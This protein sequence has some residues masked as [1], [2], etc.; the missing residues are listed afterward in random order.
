MLTNKEIS[1]E[2]IVDCRRRIVKDIFG[3]INNAN[4]NNS[5]AE[6]KREEIIIKLFKICGITN[7]MIGDEDY[8]IKLVLFLF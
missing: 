3:I 2:K 7:D 4:N 1:K 8:S 6:S 5:L